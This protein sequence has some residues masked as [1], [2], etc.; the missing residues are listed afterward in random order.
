VTEIRPL[1]VI[2]CDDVRRE[3]SY[4]DILIGVYSGDILIYQLPAYINIAIWME[5]PPHRKGEFKIDM[6]V[7]YR[8]EPPVQF[9]L[10]AVVNG[11]S[12]PFSIY[13]PPIPIRIV[14]PGQI[15]ISARHSAQDKWK[16]IKNKAVKYQAIASPSP[17]VSA[18]P[19]AP[20]APAAQE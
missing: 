16:V 4:K 11:D 20:A 9:V 8:E 15:K 5:M 14:K 10:S 3:M 2:I 7:E 12:E 6:K 13:T 18:Q 17:T 19:F 1:A